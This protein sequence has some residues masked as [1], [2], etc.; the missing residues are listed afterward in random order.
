MSIPVLTGFEICAIYCT[1]SNLY[2]S[3]DKPLNIAKE[4]AADTQLKESR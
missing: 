3:G 2:L 4:N 1:L